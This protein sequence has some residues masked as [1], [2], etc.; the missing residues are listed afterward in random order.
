MIKSVEQY[1]NRLRAALREA[2]AATVQ[3]A[4]ADAEE[5]L[6]SALDAARAEQPDRSDEDLLGPIVDKYGGPEEIAA[7]YRQ[8]E[9]RVRPALARR[10][11]EDT[12]PYRPVTFFGVLSDPRAWGAFVY[13]LIAIILGSIYFAWAIAGISLSLS[14]I[15]L[16]IG[17]PITLLFLMSVRG[18]ALVEGRI[19]EALLGVRMPRRPRYHDERAGLW[20]RCKRLL[21][22][23]RTWS[24]L[25][26][27]ILMYPL[28]ILYSVLLWTLVGLSLNM[29][30]R[31]I[32]RYF[33][34]LPLTMIN[35]HAI[36]VSDD[37]LPVVVILGCL[38]FVLTMHL[39]RLIGAW[40]GWLAK[41]MLV[42]E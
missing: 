23:G 38:L 12:R 36:Y 18:I 6:R 14:T 4:L 5:Y 26:Y 35:D 8:I 21:S 16:I 9:Y 19:I 20:N 33:W 2:D 28:G 10:E 22:D 34:D 3:D 7:A 1:L 11:P 37:Y 31:P 13:C 32:I 42:R 24:T 25:G 41:S 39:A 29:A 40:H 30:L 17:F 27:L 15:V